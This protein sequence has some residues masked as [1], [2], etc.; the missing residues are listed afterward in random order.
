MGWFAVIGIILHEIFYSS[1]IIE[2]LYTLQLLITAYIAF[3]GLKL[4]KSL[5][6]SEDVLKLDL[7]HVDKKNIIL[8][9]GSFYIIKKKKTIEFF[10]A[11]D[12]KKIARA[13]YSYMQDNLQWEEMVNLLTPY[14]KRNH[15]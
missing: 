2:Y 9:P 7:F 1:V 10:R 8:K 14:V 4:I 6:I 5:T 13:P 3:R 11:T 15:K 12:N